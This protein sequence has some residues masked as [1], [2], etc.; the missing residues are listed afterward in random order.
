[1]WRLFRPRSC[2]VS[3]KR[4]ICSARRRTPSGSWPRWDGRNRVKPGRKPWR[5]CVRSWALAKKDKDQ[6]RAR[7]ERVAVFQPEFVD[8][9]RYWVETDRRIA[10][11]AFDLIE[12]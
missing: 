4:P 12:A 8:D 1:M 6:S 10:L 9:L 7:P 11:K 5:R 3:S 2:P